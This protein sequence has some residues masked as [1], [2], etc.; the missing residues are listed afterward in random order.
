M[1]QTHMYFFM[2]ILVDCLALWQELAVDDPPHI[3]ECDFDC[4]AFFGLGDIGVFN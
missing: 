4:Y 3:E 1:K 2:D